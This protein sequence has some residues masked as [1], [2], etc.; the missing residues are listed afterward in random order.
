[1]D[2]LKNWLMQSIKMLQDAIRLP[3]AFLLGSLMRYLFPHM[4]WY[5]LLLIAFGLYWIFEYWLDVIFG[6]DKRIKIGSIIP[7]GWEDSRWLTMCW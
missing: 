1:M 3:V 5:Y 4:K 2:R 6:K 7:F